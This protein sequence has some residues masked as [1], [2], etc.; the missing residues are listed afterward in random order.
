MRAK[1][2][3]LDRPL[4]G[5]IKERVDDVLAAVHEYEVCWQDDIKARPATAEARLRIIGFIADSMAILS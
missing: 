5:E 1:R 2:E 3:G 4:A